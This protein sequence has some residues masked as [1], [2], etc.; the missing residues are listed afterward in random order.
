MGWRAGFVP[1]LPPGG[2]GLCASLWGRLA[3]TDSE[4]SAH[5]LCCF[6]LSSRVLK[7]VGTFSFLFLRLLITV[8]NVFGTGATPP[9]QVLLLTP[10][11]L[12]GG[13][14]RAAS[15]AAA[16]QLRGAGQS[17]SQGGLL[18]IRGVSCDHGEDLLPGQ[19][20]LSNRLKQHVENHLKETALTLCFGVGRRVVAVGGTL[21][22]TVLTR[23][24][25]TPNQR[26]RYGLFSPLN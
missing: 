25:V 24:S 21:G 26:G 2:P 13:K 9:S 14:T 12:S 15:L 20:L 4:S 7:P 3:V 18:L 16:A 6:L 22:R 17:Q 8:S 19:H 5:S 11:E 10:P 23:T 1:L